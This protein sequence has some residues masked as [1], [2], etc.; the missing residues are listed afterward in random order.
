MIAVAIP[1]HEHSTG[2][3]FAKVPVILAIWLGVVL[4][5]QLAKADDRPNILIVFSDDHATRAISAYDRTLINT[6][7]MDRL[8][9]EGMRFTNCFATSAVCSASRAVMLTGKHSHI[10]GKT[11]NF[12]TEFD[13][14]QDTFP[15]LLQQSGY[16]TAHFGKWHLGSAPSGFDDWIVLPGQ[17]FY[18]QPEFDTANGRIAVDGYVTDIVTDMSLE[19]LKERRDPE[20]PFLLM[21]QHKAPHRECSAA[22]EHLDLFQDSTVPEP[23]TLFEDFASRGEPGRK[24]RIRIDGD[25]TLAG[26][27]KVP[28]SLV[29][30]SRNVGKRVFDR[31][32]SRLNE[33]ERKTW[34]DAYDAEN[35]AFV[36]AKLQGKDL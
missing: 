3:N 33:Q 11:F 34:H 15:K 23:E 35:E 30:N 1:S 2:F 4:S 28:P 21:C 24:Q 25:L 6:P 17:G 27:L 10:N 12:G 22:V 14:S 20:R 36:N 29:P 7:N 19:W 26:D 13:G 18:Y 31:W 16:Q 9:R 5:G 8:A 32:Y